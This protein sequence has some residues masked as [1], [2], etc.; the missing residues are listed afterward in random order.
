MK[1]P[2]RAALQYAQIRNICYPTAD[3]PTSV[4]RSNIT[5]TRGS[6]IAETNGWELTKVNP[7]VFNTQTS[8][9]KRLLPLVHEVSHAEHLEYGRGKSNH[10]PGFW[11][12]Y[13]SNLN[14]ILQSEQ[15][16]GLVQSVFEDDI[17]WR[18]VRYRAVQDVYSSIIDK[19]CET[20][21]E[22]RRKLAESIGY[23]GYDTFE[24]DDIGV[25]V[26]TE[27]PLFHDDEYT[28]VIENLH[29]INRWADEYTDEELTETIEMCREGDSVVIPAP[30]VWISEECVDDEGGMKR[31]NRQDV[32]I[33]RGESLESVKRRFALMDRLDI[34]PY[35]TD[36][37]AFA[38]ESVTVR[39]A[40]VAPSELGE[41][42]FLGT[43][44]IL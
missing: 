13:A 12:S 14:T 3:S 15:H 43:S 4:F 37:R 20:V 1:Y 5:E 44:S 41:K 35:A 23:E 34:S 18:R 28:V 19:R 30:V 42:R 17:S 22:R 21:E 27:E 11:E 7:R 40:E 33:V 38:D 6:T 26:G 16:R 31:V 36:A 29:R 39:R 10:G 24:A 32:R 9:E 8:P 2:E 25:A